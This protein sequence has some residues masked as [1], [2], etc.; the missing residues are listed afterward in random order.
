MRRT[1]T[2]TT[3]AALAAL[4]SASLASAAFTTTYY[5]DITSWSNAVGGAN[6]C[7]WDFDPI[8]T[9]VSNG[10]ASFTDQYADFGVRAIGEYTGSGSVHPGIPYTQIGMSPQTAWV[11]PNMG[12]S[13]GLSAAGGWSPIK[14]D[15][16]TT[17]VAF[18]YVGDNPFA[19]LKFLL[20]RSDPYEYLGQV[21]ISATAA[22]AYG[23]PQGGATFSV[24]VA[25]TVDVEFDVVTIGWNSATGI[26]SMWVPTSAIP[27]PGVLPLL[28]L[29]AGVRRRRR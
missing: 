20:Y 2:I 26:E 25:F 11:F 7:T 13:S 18:H 28:A 19:S 9:P 27:A 16:P 5:N 21:T 1:D 29:A 4:A 23:T 10:W 22:P 15:A 6:E 3:V 12:L 14:F 24:L 8:G 17:G